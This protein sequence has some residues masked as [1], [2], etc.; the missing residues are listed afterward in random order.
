ME[1]NGDKNGNDTTEKEIRLLERATLQTKVLYNFREH[2]LPRHHELFYSTLT[3]HVSK[4]T[5]S[6]GMSQWVHTWVPV[7]R[8]SVQTAKKLGINKMQSI[9]SYFIP[10]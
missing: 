8:S 6:V 9:R 3:E 4:E 5:K 2:V 7:I 10:S 1:Q